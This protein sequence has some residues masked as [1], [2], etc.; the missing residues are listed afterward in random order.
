VVRREVVEVDYVA[1]GCNNLVRR[2]HQTSLANVDIVDSA[3][4][5]GLRKSDGEENE[6]GG[7]VKHCECQAVQIVLAG[8]R[9]R[10]SLEKR[11]EAFKTSESLSRNECM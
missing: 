5:E 3:V 11:Y 2:K 7:E 4:R 9:K 6:E 1:N 8:L 10:K